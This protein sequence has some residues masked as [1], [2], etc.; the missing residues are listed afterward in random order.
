MK[1]TSVQID[2][3]HTQ[4]EDVEGEKIFYPFDAGYIDKILNLLVGLNC[5]S[6]WTVSV[7][8]HNSSIA[9]SAV[10]DVRSTPFS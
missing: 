2:A 6:I 4:R 9:C 7:G 8:L 5:A 1:I 10:T 3:W